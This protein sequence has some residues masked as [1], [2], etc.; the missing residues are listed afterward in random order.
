MRS[1][2]ALWVTAL[3]CAV[4][5]FG[6]DRG[7]LKLPAF[8]GLEE[9]A[10]ETVQVNVDSKLLGLACRFLSSEE[11]DERAAQ[12]FCT[13]LTGVYVRQFTFDSDYAYPKSDIDGIRRQLLS[14]GWSQIVNARSRKENTDVTVYILVDGGKAKSLA[15][16]ASEPREFTIV[17]IV[18]N[19]DLDQ[20]HDLEGNFGVP[21]LEIETGKKPA[22]SPVP[23]PAPAPKPAPKKN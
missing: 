7:L 21:K 2:F 20:L 16:I 22:A 5:A 3:L 17:N 1:R 18:G 15:I 23:A 11:P 8:A 14:P 10:S 6:Q 4:P 13:S 9:K 19:I 12:K